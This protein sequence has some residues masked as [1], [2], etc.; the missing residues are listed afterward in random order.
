MRRF[1]EPW[2]KIRGDAVD[3]GTD[4]RFGVVCQQVEVGENFDEAATRGEP[5][6]PRSNLRE[7]HAISGGPT[8]QKGDQGVETSVCGVTAPIVG[9]SA[10]PGVYRSG[11]EHGVVGF[12]GWMPPG[13][14]SRQSRLSAMVVRF[15]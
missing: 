1:T 12:Q 5:M 3:P 7:R 4:R 6:R 15:F 11:Y 13:R 10:F 8:G 14:A 9:G 2:R